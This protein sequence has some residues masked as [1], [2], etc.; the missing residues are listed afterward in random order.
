MNYW[1]LIAVL[2]VCLNVVVTN[3]NLK[4]SLES[5][6]LI[7]DNIIDVVSSH[8]IN[9]HRELITL[10][11][12]INEKHKERSYDSETQY[13]DLKA[14]ILHNAA[15]FYRLR[16][17][18]KAGEERECITPSPVMPPTKKVMRGRLRLEEEA[19]P[20][21]ESGSKTSDKPL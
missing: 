3:Y 16:D 2:F 21:P 10:R 20:P 17:Q 4:R 6:I 1:I 11:A 15:E 19:A 13:R 5:Q 18:L 7:K 9:I 14:E 12:L 8:S